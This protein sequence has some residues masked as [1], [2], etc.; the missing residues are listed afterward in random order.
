M[1]FPLISYVIQIFL[2][3]FFHGLGNRLI[4]CLFHRTGI[5]PSLAWVKG[6]GPEIGSCANGPE[7]TLHL[8]LRNERRHKCWAST[9]Y[10]GA[11]GEETDFWLDGS[12]ELILS[13]GIQNVD[14]QLRNHMLCPRKY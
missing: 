10:L 4:P 3:V 2:S 5:L 11:V 12:E 8:I 6:D 7:K 9:V 14:Q 13:R 1:D